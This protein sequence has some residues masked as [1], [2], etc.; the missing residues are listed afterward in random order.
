M[1]GRR[2]RRLLPADRRRHPE[3]DG[4]NGVVV[5][6][7]WEANLGSKVHPWGVDTPDQ[8]PLYKLC[9]RHAALALKAGG[10][11]IKVEWTNSKKTSNDSIH[12]LD[13]NPGDD[14][15]DLWACTTMTLGL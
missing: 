8:V 12:V 11:I 14:V 5:R 2:V 4:A 1:R 9:W 7:G 3:D 15:T 6:L 13:M 10:P